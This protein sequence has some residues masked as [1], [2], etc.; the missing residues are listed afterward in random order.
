MLLPFYVYINFFRPMIKKSFSAKVSLVCYGLTLS[1]LGLLACSSQGQVTE[2]PLPEENIRLNQEGFYPQAPKI[3]VLAQGEASQFYIVN[4]D[5]TD[6]VYTG[7]LSETLT[8]SYSD[9][10]TR[11]ADFSDFT[12]EGEFVVLIP[13]VGH[14]YPFKIGENILQPVAKGVLK[15]FY[16][17]RASTPIEE[18]LGGV[19]HRNGGHP[20]TQVEVHPSAGSEQRP[21]GTVISSPRGWYDAGDY[22][23]Y[24]V[25]SGI[26]T[27]TLL[28]LYED[29]PGYFDTLS[30]NI[31]ESTNNTPDLLDEILWNL[32]WMMTMQDPNDGGVYHKLTTSSFEGM[33]MPDKAKKQRYVVQKGTAATLDFAAVM[34]Q[35][36]RI[37]RSFESE[38]PGLA[39][40]CQ[41]AAI[42]AW[43]WAR[44]NPDILYDQNA[45]NEQFDPKVTTGAYGDRDVSDEFI[46][47]ASELYVTTQQDSFYTA[48]ELFPDDAMPIPTWNQV[49]L[50]G[51]YSLVRH[52]DALSEVAQKGVLQL[53]AQ[54][55]GL[56]DAL[57][58]G[59]DQQPYHT[60]MGKTARDF[61]WGSSSNAANQGIALIQAYQL[62]GDASYLTYALHNIDYLLGRN[63]T[64]YSFVTGYGD[65]TPMHPHHRPSVADGITEPVPGL[66]SGGPNARAPQQDHCSGYTD[67]APEATFTDDDCSYASNEIAINWNAP[68]AYLVGAIEVLQDEVE[69]SDNR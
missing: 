19:W 46:W 59:V 35:A 31:P 50:L 69:F 29:F 67:T 7:K 53:K 5:L 63:A 8:S 44:Q 61:N 3:A 45:M 25:N 38:L 2:S 57:I 52:Q 55:I 34:A 43:G 60:V 21:A 4:A 62:T 16:Y 66:L 37:F 11:I 6:T 12:S 32:R 54:I 17:I 15:A 39:D 22:N 23:K 51:Y 47:A 1:L 64:G 41:Q 26:T 13:E 49:R 36:T 56:A 10:T 24:I 9:K 18:K 48:V 58:K 28:S 68:L 65:K 33:I 30:L 14:S 40:S 27:A 42:T 20:D